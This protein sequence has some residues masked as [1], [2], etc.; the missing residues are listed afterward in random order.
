V[1]SCAV[2]SVGHKLMIQRNPVRVS[3]AFTMQI[4]S[5]CSRVP[6]HTCWT[7][8]LST[9][10]LSAVLSVATSSKNKCLDDDDDTCT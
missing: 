6:T 5:H 9:L 8:R 4:S 3:F 2:Q 1:G 7:G 10:D